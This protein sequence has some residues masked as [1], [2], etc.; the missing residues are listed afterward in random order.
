VHLVS[1]LKYP[2]AGRQVASEAVWMR[3]QMLFQSGI[4]P[5]RPFSILVEE[6]SQAVILE[7]ILLA[8]T[9]RN[10]KSLREREKVR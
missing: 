8:W 9:K 3:Q 4:S 6:A 7:H 1:E 5:R 2:R 10:P